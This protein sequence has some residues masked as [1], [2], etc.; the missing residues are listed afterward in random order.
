MLQHEGNGCDGYIVCPVK[1]HG[2]SIREN[3]SVLILS[4][5]F[6]YSV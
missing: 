4:F 1:K 6:K 2:L 5:M 3:L